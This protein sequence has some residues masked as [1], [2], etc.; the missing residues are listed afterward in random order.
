MWYNKIMKSRQNIL[1]IIKSLLDLFEKD[2]TLW[3]ELTDIFSNISQIEPIDEDLRSFCM[4]AMIITGE[5]V[6]GDS[7]YKDSNILNFDG[8]KNEYKKLS[9]GTQ[10]TN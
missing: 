8:L 7:V 4:D 2:K 1:N 5:S 10:G 3:S 9:D 6:H